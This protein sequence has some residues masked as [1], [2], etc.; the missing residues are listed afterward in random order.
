MGETRPITIDFIYLLILVTNTHSSQTYNKCT[1]AFCITYLLKH[2]SAIVNRP[3]IAEAN[4][5]IFTFSIFVIVWFQLCMWTLFAPQFFTQLI[6]RQK[7]RHLSMPN[8]YFCTWQ[9]TMNYVFI[10]KLCCWLANLHKSMN[11][12]HDFTSFNLQL[13]SIGR[14]WLCHLERYHSW[15]E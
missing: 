13:I 11:G 3:G 7:F 14:I 1:P 5:E 2:K 9:I 8:F 4:Q 10:N 15:S 6:V 12:G